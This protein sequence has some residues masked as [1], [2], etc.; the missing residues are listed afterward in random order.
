MYH[1]LD[2]E[3]DTQRDAAL[4]GTYLLAVAG[5]SA[6]NSSVSYSFEVFDNIN[7]TSMLTVG[8]P[9]T[10]TLPNPGDLAS[11]TFTGSPARTCFL[12]ASRHHPE[13]TLR[14]MILA[15]ELSSV[16]SRRTATTGPTRSRE[17]GTYTLTVS[18]SGRSTG[19]YDFRLLDTSAQTLTPTSTATTVSGTITPGTG[20]NI[21][22]HRGDSRRADHTH[23]RL[24]LVNQGNLVPVQSQQ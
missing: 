19:T 5:Q 9:V 4:R 14:Y 15:T 10:G 11:Y 24:V 12:T 17:P 8:D 3:D 18:G 23:E 6:A 7:P 16:V 21:Y 2:L 22:Q 20:S 1:Y 13:S